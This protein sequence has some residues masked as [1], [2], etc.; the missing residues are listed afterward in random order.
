V[1]A[2]PADTSIPVLIVDD[3]PTALRIVRNLLQKIGFENIDEANG[4]YTALKQIRAKHYGLIISDWNMEPISGYDL[5]RHVRADPNL[6]PIRFLMV[7]AESS[8]KNVMAAKQAGV[9]HYIVKPF[10]VLTLKSKIDAI[11]PN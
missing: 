4:G 6:G 3:S 8:T 9:D 11:F 7:T 1:A 5:L 10:D 2:V